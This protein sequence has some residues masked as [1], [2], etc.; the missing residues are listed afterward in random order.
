MD[1]ERRENGN[2]HSVLI[3][4]ILDCTRAKSEHEWAAAKEIERLRAELLNESEA[5][6]RAEEALRLQDGFREN[7]CEDKYW[8][9]SC[10]ICGMMARTEDTNDGKPI[11]HWRI[12]DGMLRDA[13][14]RRGEKGEMA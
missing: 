3:A 11:C 12:V 13:A 2:T 1:S 14:L 8:V 5:R 9:R 4:Q 10:H 7:R 6:E